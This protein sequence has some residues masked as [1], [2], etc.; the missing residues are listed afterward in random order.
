MRKLLLNTHLI[1]GLIAA[2]FLLILGGTGAV[3]VFEN[4]IDH[5]LNSKLMKLQPSG[6]RLSYN[7]LCKKLE[8]KYPGAK[9]NTFIV[10]TDDEIA[11]SANLRGGKTKGANVYV[12][13]YTGEVLGNVSDRNSFMSK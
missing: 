4:E 13:P 8:E 6:E 9:V 5:S 2:V 1:V 7:A 10:S 3:L 11:M 12:N